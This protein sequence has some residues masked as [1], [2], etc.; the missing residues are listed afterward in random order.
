MS[1]TTAT[2]KIRRAL[3]SV[4]DKTGLVDLAQAMHQTGTELYASGGTFKTLQDAKI[5]CRLAEELAE[6]PEA[7]QGRMKTLSFKI[8]SGILA[9]REDPKDKQDWE[10]LNIKLLDAVVVN[11]YPFQ[12]NMDKNL[13]RAELTELIDIGGPA[14]V[15]AA[16]K[17]APDVVVLTD[18]AQY[19]TVIAQLKSQ[20]G[21][22]KA[23]AK[24]VAGQAWDLVTDYDLS[25]Q[26]VFGAGTKTLRYGENPHQKASLKVHGNSP[27]DW[28]HPLTSTELSYNNI[29]DLSSAY[30]VAR[31][32][33][34]AFPDKTSVVIV[35]HNNPCGVATVSKTAPKAQL[36]ALEKAWA[37]DPVSAFGG[38]L[39]FTDEIDAE[40]LQ[41]FQNR[42][43]ELI[44]APKLKD[45]DLKDLLTQRKN[46]KAVTVKHWDL[47]SPSMQM[48]V[49]GGTLTQ[50]LDQQIDEPLKGVTEVPW[51]HQWNALAH[52]GIFC[53][54]TLKSN[55][56]CL[57]CED[58]EG[59]FRMVGAGQGQPNRVEAME[60]LA[61]PRA[62]NVL[63]K[64]D[65]G[66][67]ILISD[68][69]FP[70][71]DSVDVAARAGIRAIVQPGGSIKDSTV[72]AACN[73]HKI[74]MAFTGYRHFRH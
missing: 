73:E 24:E 54:K 12:K 4:S 17:N 29:V 72:I 11:F 7:F 5:P 65:L 8:F 32:L 3:L 67:C 42:F 38:V 57:V 44:S 9:R 51:Q 41:Y 48:S 52:F 18:P 2:V 45:S 31:D 37:C 20:G 74:A 36:R 10:K 15:R 40:I 60:K 19:S 69:F 47:D 16:A 62:Q 56:V 68:A 22:D 43:V 63:N 6:T 30:F 34:S 23:T 59:D 50:S 55:S 58:S 49:A 35:K 46:L 21:V 53:N 71:R 25:I 1:V 14:L 61:I 26:S 33:K 64:K 28:N 13:S 27:L 70:F 39:I 66:E